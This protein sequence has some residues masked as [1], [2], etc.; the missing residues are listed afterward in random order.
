L[1]LQAMDKLQKLIKDLRTVHDSDVNT[2]A[3]LVSFILGNV[4]GSSS[5]KAGANVDE[6]TLRQRYAFMYCKA[7]CET[8]LQACCIPVFGSPAYTTYRPI[9]YYTATAMTLRKIDT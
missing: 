2:S 9:H 3:Q 8:L 5:A 7:S 4:N 1:A 6:Q